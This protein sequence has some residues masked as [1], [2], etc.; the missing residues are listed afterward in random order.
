MIRSV[1]GRRTEWPP[2]K[3]VSVLYPDASE[4]G[5][6]AYLLG[7]CKPKWRSSV[8]TCSLANGYKPIGSE[9]TYHFGEPLIFH[10][11]EGQ[12]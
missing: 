7:A 9:A 6:G 11:L 1:D 3:S 5:A 10:L 4:S 8:A 2:W 12:T